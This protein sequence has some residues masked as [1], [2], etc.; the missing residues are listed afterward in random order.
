MMDTILNGGMRI[1]LKA[2]F[3]DLIQVINHSGGHLSMKISISGGVD[4]DIRR[5]SG[6][7]FRTPVQSHW[8]NV[9]LFN[10]LRNQ[11]VKT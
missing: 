5:R 7:S 1:I 6:S 3:L 8:H 10:K 9:H 11:K 2:E 4:K